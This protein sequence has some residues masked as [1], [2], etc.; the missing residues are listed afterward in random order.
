MTEHQA[1]TEMRSVLFTDLVGSTELRVRVGEDQAENLRRTHDRLLADAVISHGG[2]VVK[3]LGDGIL[4]TFQSAADA[5]SAAEAIQ[6]AVDL[7]AHQQPEQA[8]AVRVGISAG[9]VTVESSDV[10]GVPVVEASR[11]C[12]AAAG[13]EILAAELVRTLSRGRGNHIFEPMGNLELKGLPEPVPA[14]RVPWEPLELADAAAHLA[15]V[16]FPTLLSSTSATGYVGRDELLAKLDVARATATSG[17]CRIVLLAGEPG[18]GKTRTAAELAR[19][20]HGD[21]AVVLYGRCDE[22]LGLSYQ[23]LME[24]LDWYTEHSSEPVLGRLPG[25]LVRLLPQLPTRVPGLAPPVASDPRSEEHLLFESTASWLLEL[26]REHDVVLV[27]DDLH[28]ATKPTLLLLLHV[29]RAGIA[30]ETSTH[31]LVVGT[32]RDTDID[33]SHPLSGVLADLRRWPAVDRLSIEGLNA[34]EVQRFIKAAAG[35]DLDENILAL[36]ATVYDETEG[37]PF[38]V[39][40]VLRHLVEIGA[41]YRQEDRWVLQDPGTFAVPEGVR[42]VIGRRLS[43]LSPVSND[44]LSMASVIGR[45]IDV[46]LLA[47]LSDTS[48]DRMLDALDEAVRARLV[49]ETRA[50]RYRFSHA[51]VRTTLYD[52]LSAT[53][54]RRLHRRVAEALEK[55]QSDDVVALAFHYVEAGPDG[56][57]MT[58]AVH[59]TLS[60][61]EQA[62][63]ARALAD[64]EARFCQ[65][66][67][68]LDDVE[69]ADCP[70]RVAALCGLGE[71]QRDQGNPAFRATLLEASRLA[72]SLGEV[73]LLVR[74]VLANSRG[75]MSVVG[76]IDEERIELV[77]VA[78]DAV[79]G[80]PS[81]ERARLLAQL[82]SEVCFAGDHE[83]RLALADEAESMARGLGDL[84]LLAWVLARTGFAVMSIDRAARLVARGAEATHLADATGDPALRVLTRVWW[85]SD[86]L[87]VGDIAGM[88]RVT[89]ELVAIGEDCSPTIRWDARSFSIR[90]LLLDGR[91]DEAH[92]LND[93]CLA[94]GQAIG[95]PDATMWWAALVSGERTSRGYPGATADEAAA[96]ADQY[97]GAPTWRMAQVQALA[98]AGDAEGVRRVIEEYG[99]EPEKLV[100]EPFPLLG[101]SGFADAAYRLGDRELAARCAR[102]LQPHRGKWAHY[103]LATS[104]PVEFALG[105]CALVTGDFDEAAELLATACHVLEAAGAFGLLPQAHLALAEALVGRAGDGDHERVLELINLGRLGA[106]SIS[107]PLL[108]ERADELT[109]LAG[110]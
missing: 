77:E 66:L 57:L 72:L 102:L 31:L 107:A 103:L 51:L 95:E 81:G 52:E 22:D 108:V 65:V 91:L 87:T 99:L 74:A 97:P 9:D 40:E 76:S 94:L 7:H 35:H 18:V 70:E 101:A 3:G 20:A 41:V 109:A 12:A 39:G 88:R 67:E 25:E 82:A 8:F 36:A 54:R 56:G 73:A 42:D 26:A 27:I 92:R 98:F 19:R 5:V 50:D 14:C 63:A 75:I 43:R 89:D 10:F 16:A 79:G 60:A 38:F 61:G 13:G 44:L 80:E 24:A 28:W 30:A 1:Q 105:R 100:A 78:L 64:A 46:E 37:N 4:A 86:L 21:G 58:R 110:S 93:E 15:D 71:C 83:R 33:R 104:F 11:L 85:S 47:A 23:P 2:Q 90:L 106:Q 17:G 68:V 29:L 62:L 34:E 49:D 45:D 84:D 6:Q 55:L 53:R 69:L 96:F 59:Y 32:Y 48:E